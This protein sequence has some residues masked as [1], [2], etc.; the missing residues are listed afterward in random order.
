MSVEWFSTIA[1]AF[2][3]LLAAVYGLSTRRGFALV[4][5]AIALSW[6]PA[7]IHAFKFEFAQEKARIEQHESLRPERR[8]RGS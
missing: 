2:A 7:L 6:A 3:L 4:V 1:A 8:T 5:I